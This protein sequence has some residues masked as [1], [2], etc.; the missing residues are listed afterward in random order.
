[1]ADGRAPMIFQE[2][3]PISILALTDPRDPNMVND[4]MLVWAA[5]GEAGFAF[6]DPRCAIRCIA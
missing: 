3:E 5:K 1:M 4:D 2:T 6:A